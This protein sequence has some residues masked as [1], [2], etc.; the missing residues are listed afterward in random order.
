[1]SHIFI[2]TGTSRNKDPLRSKIVIENK[3]S[4]IDKGCD[5]SI[6]MLSYKLTEI[7]L[8]N[9]K[10]PLSFFLKTNVFKIHS[11]LKLSKKKIRQPILQLFGELIAS[12]N[13]ETKS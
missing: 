9:L 6:E 8:T 2:K 4:S 13:S 3:C 11:L 1:M 7:R 12:V 10:T 5:L